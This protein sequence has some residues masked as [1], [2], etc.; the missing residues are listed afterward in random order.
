MSNE[1]IG[2]IF[3]ALLFGFRHG[4]DW[5]HIAAITD[6]VGGEGDKK[7]GL[8]LSFWYAFG[9]EVVIVVLGGM[10]VLVGLSIPDW[11]DAVME[12]VV[13][14]TL[15]LLA[16]FML[17][18]LYR[19]RKQ[20]E[21]IMVSRWRILFIGFYNV[22]ARITGRFLGNHRMFD[23]T[24]RLDVSRTGAFAIGIAHGIGAETPTQLLLFTTVASIGSP[25]YGFLTVFAFVIGLFVSHT[26]LALV[27][28]MG[29]KRSLKNK[30]VFQGVAL[31]T[32]VYSL[33][34]GSL[35]ILGKSSILPSIL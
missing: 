21:F 6:L 1:V 5:D 26:L 33:G 3:L 23:S 13:G 34:I 15:I 12:R 18:F 17:S 7:K 8:I 30:W 10:A 31:A 25:Y 35:C 4:I 24:I 28:L 32:S 22:F 14:L 2:L 20:K 11:V 9:H 19:N 27:S 29:F 16:I